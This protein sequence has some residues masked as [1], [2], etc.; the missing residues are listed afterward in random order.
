MLSRTQYNIQ[1]SNCI[2]QQCSELYN[3]VKSGPLGPA[4]QCPWVLPVALLSSK[5]NRHVPYTPNTQPIQY[6]RNIARLSFHPPKYLQHMHT[7]NTGIYIM[8]HFHIYATKQQPATHTNAIKWETNRVFFHVFNV[9]NTDEY[10]IPD[11]QFLLHIPY[12]LI[13]FTVRR[14]S[15]YFTI[16]AP[17]CN[18]NCQRSCGHHHLLTNLSMNFDHVGRACERRSKRGRPQNSLFCC[19]FKFCRDLCAF[20]KTFGELSTKIIII[21]MCFKWK[22]KFRHHTQTYGL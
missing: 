15:I 7:F 13:Q 20:W 1:W 3:T 10:W 12:T 11:P 6:L 18:M 14:P 4:G 21:W 8:L 2:A 17:H 16:R 5:T 22:P 9:H 19:K